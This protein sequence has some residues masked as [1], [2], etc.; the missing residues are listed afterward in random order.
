MVVA[1]TVTSRTWN[2]PSGVALEMLSPMEL[3]ELDVLVLS[4]VRS[5]IPP[6]WLPEAETVAWLAA[7]LGEVIVV[8]DYPEPSIST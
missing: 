4:M 5:R 3:Y 1:V 8:A 7:V 6:C 2:A